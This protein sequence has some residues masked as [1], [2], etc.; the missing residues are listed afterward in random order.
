MLKRSNCH[1]S[2]EKIISLLR[3]G[4]IWDAWLEG[5]SSKEAK[6]RLLRPWLK[7]KLQ[8]SGLDISFLFMYKKY[9]D[10]NLRGA[11]YSLTRGAGKRK[12]AH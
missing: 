11:K 5:L 9:G 4:S 1:K 2:C 7:L 12:E 8:K 6:E 3:R 10:D